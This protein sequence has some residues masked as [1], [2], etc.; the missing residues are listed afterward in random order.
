MFA[1]SN[2]SLDRVLSESRTET[3][4]AKSFISDS[5]LN[6]GGNVMVPIPMSSKY[7]KEI[8]K[9][10]IDEIPLSEG[11]LLLLEY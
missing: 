9:R 6:P 10:Q 8:T 11:S 2:N 3:S 5:P 1:S 7:V 4:M